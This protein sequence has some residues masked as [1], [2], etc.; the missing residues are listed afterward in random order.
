MIKSF[1]FFVILSC[2]LG[3][4]VSSKAIAQ[5]SLLSIEVLVNDEPITT[6][7]VEKRLRFVIARAGGVNSQEEFDQLRQQ[8]VESMISEILQ[9]QEAKNRFEYEMSDQEIEPL[10]Q[11]QAMSFGMT[12]EQFEATLQEIGSNK[13]TII[14]QMRA[15]FVWADIT[16]GRLGDLVS[17]SDEEVE[18]IINERREHKGLFEY[19]ISE[20]E[21]LVTDA[22]QEATIKAGAENLVNQIRKGAAFAE[23]ARQLSASP[24]A[25]SG[26]ARGWVLESSLSDKQRDILQNMKVGAVSDPIRSPGGYL[27]LSLDDRRRVLT[28]DKMDN[29]FTLAQVF[30]PIEDTTDEAKATQFRNALKKAGDYTCDNVDELWNLAGVVPPQNQRPIFRARDILLSTKEDISVFEVGQ[31]TPMYEMEDGWRMLFV[32]DIQEAKVQEPDFEEVLER[33]E[34]Q[35]LQKMS[36]RWLRDLRRAAI[37]DMR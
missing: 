35:R 27:I 8:V 21:L 7:D 26:G 17:V 33:L 5:E 29:Q 4:N 11:R 19:N 32:C 25:S 24:T 14:Q 28:A 23:I 1:K 12:I 10:F 20:I 3:I 16:R 13:S 22:T 9:V 15:E 37:I 34:E 6:Y 31:H 2:F 30:L 18:A 36:R